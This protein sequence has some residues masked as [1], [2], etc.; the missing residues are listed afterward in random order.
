MSYGPRIP[1]VNIALGSFHRRALLLYRAELTEIISAISDEAKLAG[2]DPSDYLPHELMTEHSATKQALVAI[3]RLQPTD[4]EDFRELAINVGLNGPS[5]MAMAAAVAIMR[6]ELESRLQAIE[7]HP[8]RV[9]GA[10]TPLRR[11]L[12]TLQLEFEHSWSKMPASLMLEQVRERRL[13]KRGLIYPRRIALDVALQI[14]EGQEIDFKER[15]P[16]QAHKLAKEFAGF[17]TS[18]PGMIFVGVTNDGTVV[19][20]DGIGNLEGKDRFRQRIEGLTSNTVKPPLV[21]RVDFELYDGK[22]VARIDVPKG[23]Q[24]VYFADNVPYVRHI[25]SARPATPQEVTELVQRWSERVA[26]SEE[27]LLQRLEKLDGELT[28]AQIIGTSVPI[29]WG[30]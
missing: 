14:G 1:F 19:G 29:T 11:R 16:E 3:Q 12:E 18:N 9:E 27:H 22:W 20:V 24:P 6:E 8:L 30:T 2:Y 10:A 26:T 28:L 23:S 7:A 13:R 21:V 25:S 5:T 17:G 15:I 4:P